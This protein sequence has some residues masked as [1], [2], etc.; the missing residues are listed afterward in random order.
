M[1]DD[2]HD[3]D[4]DDDGRSK[5]CGGGFTGIGIGCSFMDI[6]EV[7]GFVIVADVI[8]VDGIGF[9]EGCG[10]IFMQ[11]DEEAGAEDG[12]TTAAVVAV[13]V[14]D[15]WIIVMGFI[16]DLDWNFVSVGRD[17]GESDVYLVFFAGDDD[18]N[19]LSCSL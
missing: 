16:I 11:E 1:T 7:D 13:A 9:R 3:D 6:M 15:A 4:A 18:D 19:T 12:L 10:C 5:L 14:A 8:D 2:E 17:K